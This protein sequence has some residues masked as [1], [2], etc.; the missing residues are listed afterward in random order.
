MQLMALVFETHDRSRFEVTAFSFGP[1]VNDAMQLRLK[2]AFEHFVDV[3]EKS[4]IEI[5]MLAKNRE[6]DIAIDLMGFTHNCRTGIFAQRLAPVQVNYLGHPG[7]M[8]TSFMDYLIADRI[9][10]PEENKSYY[11]EKIVYMPD[12]YQANDSSRKISDK[13]FARR[14]MGLPEDGFVFCCFNNS[15]KITPDLFDIWMRLL[16]KVPRSVL[17][18]FEANSSCVKNLR[19]E[20]LSRGIAEEQVIFANLMELNDHIARQQLADLFLDTFYYNAHATASHALWAGLPVLTCLG[21]TFASRVGAS[22]LHAVGLPEM[23]TYSHGEYEALALQLATDPEKLSAIH[24]KLAENK[25]TYPLFNTELFTKHIENA[26]TKM[27][28]ISQAGSASQDIYVHA[29][30]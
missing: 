16:H 12:S 11:T 29:G 30:A 8:G 18:L 24:K 23:I 15:Y 13:K 28:E 17:W 4:D 27:W 22:L 20:A 2:K 5:A 7:T 1:A 21:K 14:E 3:S 26:Y 19:K 25:M 6:I 9:L 10:I